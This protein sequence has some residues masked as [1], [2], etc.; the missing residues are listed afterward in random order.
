MQTLTFQA[1]KLGLRHI[2]IGLAGFILLLLAIGFATRTPP[3]QTPYLTIAGA[4][5][6]FNYRI[7]EVSYGFAA[8]V[9]KPVRKYSRI[10]A[11]FEDPMGGPPLEIIEK[12][13]PRSTRYSV[14]SPPVRGVEK[15]VPYRVSVRLIQNLD[16][17]VL[18]EESFT[19]TSQMSDAVV[20]PAPLTI[21][22]GYMRNPHLSDDWKR[23]DI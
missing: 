8:V 21:G 17:A 11:T 16:D 23:R 15:G 1:R 9:N 5:F 7:G 4:G 14:R 22:P 13:T 18:F 3:S 12:L 10:I 6:M 19:V 2:A 20:P